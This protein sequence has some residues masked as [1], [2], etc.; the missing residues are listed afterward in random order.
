LFLRGLISVIIALILVFSPN[1]QA[2]AADSGNGTVQDMFNNQNSGQK[3]QHSQGSSAS[4]GSGNSTTATLYG[5]SNL[6]LDFIKIVFSLVI[7]LALIYLLYRFAAK[8]TGKF[9]Q[10]S[11]LKNLGGVSVGSN[12]SIQLI[13]LGN[14]VMV[15]GVGDTVQLLKEI[16][17]PQEIDAFSNQKAEPD[18]IET[19]VY[20]I[21]KWTSAKTTGK[22]E[23]KSGNDW[24]T[25]RKVMKKDLELLKDERSEKMK[26]L[27]REVSRNE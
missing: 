27:V 13:R 4:T 14:K 6:F 11:T 21:L 1:V 2:F 23:K 8:R 19:S 18:P 10:G 7:I 26:E 9:K 25:L 24:D 22:K 3:S 15:I 12:R 5:G 16:S 20:K 17:D